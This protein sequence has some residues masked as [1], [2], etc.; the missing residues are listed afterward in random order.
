MRVYGSSPLHNYV[1]LVFRSKRLFIVSILLASVAMAGFYF[2]RTKTYNARMIVLLS[3]SQALTPTD[4]VARGSVE[5][6]L[7]ILNILVRDPNFIK[8]AMREGHLDQGKNE[9]EFSEFCKQVTASMS[10]VTDHSNILEIKCTWTNSDCVRILQAFYSQYSNKVFD[11]EMLVSTL[12][13]KMLKALLDTYRKKQHNLE[14]KVRDYELKTVAHHPMESFTEANLKYLALQGEVKRVQASLQA[15]EKQQMSIA[16]KLKNTDKNIQDSV[17]YK[18]PADMPVNMTAIQARDDATKVL[19]DLKLKYQDKA[20]QVIAAQEKLNA[21]QALVDENKNK[22]NQS[23]KPL[24]KADASSIKVN[25]NPQYQN[26][27][28]QLDEQDLT[29]TRVKSELQNAETQLQAADKRLNIAPDEKLR[30]EAMTADM[31]LY[32]KLRDDLRG[33]LEG[34]TLEELRGKELQTAEMKT[35]VDPESEVEKGGARGA[36]L[37]A[38]GPIIGIVL[39]FCFSLFAES[40]DHSMRTPAEV[41]KYFNKPV[42]AVLPRMDTKKGRGQLGSGDNR[43]SLP[44]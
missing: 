17:T 19:N 5:Y 22:A 28:S 26:L 23:N 25:I 35:M 3:G 20:P 9:L 8:T 31:G 34:A 41:E 1:E 38:A 12:R 40:Q 15:A 16:E 44:S 14:L 18:G 36:L 43:P 42:L 27:Q 21:A 37:L 4:N 7:S 39:A 11:Q 6:K 33:E 2:S 30:F 32:T 29:I 24:S 10:Y 13:T